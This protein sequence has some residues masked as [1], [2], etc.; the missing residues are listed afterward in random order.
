M[1]GATRV[2]GQVKRNERDEAN[3]RSG[4]DSREIKADCCGKR[5]P[6]NCFFITEFWI[7]MR[8]ERR[9]SAKKYFFHT[10]P[11]SWVASL[12]VS[13]PVSV[14]FHS[15]PPVSVS[16]MARREYREAITDENME[17]LRASLVGKTQVVK[18]R[19]FNFA[20]EK[21][22]LISVRTLLDN[23]VPLRQDS[24]LRAI[25]SGSLEI[26]KA[27]LSKSSVD[28]NEPCE[29]SYAIMVATKIGHLHLVRLLTQIPGINVN[30]SGAKAQ[31]V[32]FLAIQLKH[33]EIAEELVKA[34][35]KMD[36]KLQKIFDVAVLS[37]DECTAK[38]L[39]RAGASLSGRKENKKSLLIQAVEQR[40]TKGISLLLGNKSIEINQQS[41]ETGKTA[42]ISATLL[43]DE[44][45]VGLLLESNADLNFP[46][47]K[48][49]TPLICA[50][51]NNIVNIVNRLL[52]AGADVN[53]R[54]NNGMTPI[55]YSIRKRNW[56]IVGRFLK[57]G[58][59][60]YRDHL[61]RTTLLE[62]IKD[63]ASSV[64]IEAILNAG[65][66]LNFHRK[67]EGGYLVNAVRKNREDIVRILLQ[68]GAQIRDTHSCLLEKPIIHGNGK[69]IRLLAEAGVNLK[70][71]IDG[72]SPLLLALSKGKEE[73]VQALLSLG[74]DINRDIWLENESY[75]FQII[76]NNE[77]HLLEILLAHGADIRVKNK[78]GW[79]TLF[80][81]VL[82]GNGNT[83]RMLVKAGAYLE[84]RNKGETPL[85]VAAKEG[86]QES[87]NTL[88]E[89]GAD[90]KAMDSRGRTA[91]DHAKQHE[92][93]VKVLKDWENR[94]KE[95][96]ESKQG[97]RKHSSLQSSG[98]K[99]SSPVEG[100]LGGKIEEG[101][102]II[103]DV[104]T[105]ANDSAK[106]D[107]DKS[108]EE[109]KKKKS[110]VK[111]EETLDSGTGLR[112]SAR[113]SKKPKAVTPV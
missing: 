22:S 6:L 38:I 93:I 50:A 97:K 36:P 81:A 21:R 66:D 74:A 88:L 60:V 62:A 15:S 59:K 51:E 65:I 101:K 89:L 42:L 83:I 19:I 110:K 34:G 4:S 37:G 41:K 30:V 106:R 44:N 14:N 33:F 53:L 11:I 45:I 82:Y 8:G 73:S 96:P 7:A 79:S 108:E 68:N 3:Q 54:E 99:G 109:P 1:R 43:G 25:R 61:F 39:I 86:D 76:K 9:W 56:E 52:Q 98:A 72:K 111:I 24:F 58:A 26:V 40:N 28:V 91:K 55:H 87:V 70:D 18:S 103:S 20:I 16:R 57:R 102:G 92:S 78:S 71:T 75:F 95:G 10:V 112:R 94:Q 49:K 23:D 12:P 84:E 32:L 35:G 67:L 13:F 46:D 100:K 63:D 77:E 104:I 27:I 29:G 31:T 69:L 113:L 85:M 107:E 105:V 64:I 47:N 48:G 5:H 90:T 80:M 17:E 2:G